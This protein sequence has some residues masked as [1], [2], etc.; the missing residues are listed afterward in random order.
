M[1]HVFTRTGPHILHT[2]PQLVCDLRSEQIVGAIATWFQLSHGISSISIPIVAVLGSGHG[3]ELTDTVASRLIVR[4]WSVHFHRLTQFEFPYLIVETLPEILEC[5]VAIDVIPAWAAI[6][7]VHAFF[8]HVCNGIGP[9]FFRRIDH[10]HHRF[11]AFRGGRIS[12]FV[13]V[14]QGRSRTS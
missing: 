10:W 9:I 3:G 1:H 7:P 12:C 13:R 8:V 11:Q 14:I 2:I 5:D 6:R 4:I